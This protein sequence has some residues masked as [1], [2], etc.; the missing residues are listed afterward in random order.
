MNIERRCALTLEGEP[1]QRE[2][3]RSLAK[4][5]LGWVAKTGLDDGLKKTARYFHKIR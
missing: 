3:G 5:E 2:P 4:K 1:K